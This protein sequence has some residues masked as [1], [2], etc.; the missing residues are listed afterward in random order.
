MIRRW[1][2][3]LAAV[4]DEHG[5]R[6]GD[7]TKMKVF[8]ARA[9]GWIWSVI[10]C[11][12][13]VGFAFIILYP[14]LGLISVALRHS[15]ELNDPTVVWIPRRLVMDNVIRA[16]DRL[17][18]FRTFWLTVSISLVSAVISM[19]ICGFA[20]YG[21]ARFNFAGKRLL[22]GILLFT[23]LLPPQVLLIPQ[24]LQNAFFDFFGFVTL[25]NA[26]GG[27]MGTISI[28]NT[29]W[30]L[31]LPALFGQGI[32]SGLLIFIFRQFFRGMPNEL[33]DSAYV[34]GAGPF[35]AFVK[36]IIPNAVPAYLTVFLFTTVWYWSDSTFA[37]WFLGDRHTF[38][39]RTASAARFVV[40]LEGG[41]GHAMVNIID[42]AATLATYQTAMLIM[43]LPVL[44]LFIVF[45]RHFVESVEKT[46]I[47]G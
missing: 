20:G 37:P 39:M 15:S 36:I 19:I 5:M 42:R 34:D 29:V 45:Q 9:S 41:D 33:E 6:G 12:I 4:I 14:L 17:D 7:S 21:F 8:T 25:V 38:A 30:P 13:L 31:Y 28:N 2:A 32:R 23:I 26:L 11:V 44:I 22:F 47:V 40:E 1:I 46:G 43:I 18:F 3:K 10:R 35:T 24:F 27:N 16:F